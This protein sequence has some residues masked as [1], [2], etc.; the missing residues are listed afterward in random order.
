MPTKKKTHTQPASD[1]LSAEFKKFG[2][3]LEINIKA[4]WKSKQR[5]KL[6]NDIGVGLNKMVKG[7]DKLVKQAKGKGFNEKVKTG[8][9]KAVQ[10]ANTGLEKTH[11]KW[12]PHQE[13]KK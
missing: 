10:K 3:N 12:E 6:E 7:I 4:A 5:K 13:D 8:L 2:K 11:K 1:D 9:Y